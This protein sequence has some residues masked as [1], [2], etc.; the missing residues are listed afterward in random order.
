MSVLS[1]ACRWDCKAI[2][3]HAYGVVKG[4]YTTSLDRLVAGLEHDFSCWAADG[5]RAFCLDDEDWIIDEKDVERIG[6]DRLKQLRSARKE[7]QT[8]AKIDR[9]WSLVDRALAAQGL[10][11]SADW[12]DVY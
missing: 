4:L 6:A 2:K 7:V 3:R 12:S 9:I 10:S 8:H 1:L 11:T 5:Y